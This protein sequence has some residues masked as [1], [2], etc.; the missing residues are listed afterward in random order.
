MARGVLTASATVIGSGC[1][2]QPGPRARGH[3]HRQQDADKN[4]T[5]HPDSRPEAAW[6]GRQ[7]RIP[8]ERW[9]TAAA[10]YT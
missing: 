6:P 7:P 1:A 5:T 9:K 4:S 8:Q 2:P 3:A 10:P